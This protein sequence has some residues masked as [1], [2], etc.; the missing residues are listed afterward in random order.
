MRQDGD[1]MLK[2]QRFT[3][4]TPQKPYLPGRKKKIMKAIREAQAYAT[5]KQIVKILC[6]GNPLICSVMEDNKNEKRISDNH[7]RVGK[8]RSAVSFLRFPH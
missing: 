1:I 2:K 5:L 4:V 7:R 8:V 3:R 6:F